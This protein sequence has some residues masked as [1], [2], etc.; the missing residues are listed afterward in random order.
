MLLVVLCAVVALPE[1]SYK[2]LTSNDL[3]ADPQAL[4]DGASPGPS[5]PIEPP[6]L[7]RHTI[8]RWVSLQA[9][10][11]LG[12]LVRD[13]GHTDYTPP[14]PDVFVVNG[15]GGF[16]IFAADMAI[17][18]MSRY[19][20]IWIYDAK[21]HLIASEPYAIDT[22]FANM[23][24]PKYLQP[25]V[26]FFDLDG[27]GRP[28]VRVHERHHCGTSC[29]GLSAIFLNFSDTGQI[30]EMLKFERRDFPWDDSRFHD[31]WMTADIARN[32]GKLS[33]TSWLHAPHQN[34]VKAEEE[35]VECGAVTRRCAV[36]SR[37][38]FVDVGI[39][40]WA[41]SND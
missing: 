1:L 29:D 5:Q 9:K 27:D 20:A 35:L 13:Y 31:S 16:Q 33:I 25:V 8:A 3:P 4:D 34:A 15:P 39:H 2:H 7:V 21:T 28:E 41:A 38:R 14:L 11:Y 12:E 30:S 22:H 32:N 17:P 6:L 40:G 37:Q 36:T 26:S 10:E 18:S 19:Y 24:Y 23:D